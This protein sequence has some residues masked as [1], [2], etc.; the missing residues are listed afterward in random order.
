MHRNARSRR[1][2]RPRLGRLFAR[3]AATDGV[4]FEPCILRGFNRNPQA[5]AEEGWDLD[6]SLLD[7]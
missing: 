2:V 3:H 4:E 1:N 6:A 5:L 7:V